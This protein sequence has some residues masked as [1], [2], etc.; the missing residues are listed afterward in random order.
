VYAPTAAYAYQYVGS[1]DWFY[2]GAV[3]RLW[4]Q[5]YRHICKE[6][7]RQ[8]KLWVFRGGK[9]CDVDPIETTRTYYTRAFTSL[10]RL[11]LACA[12]LELDSGAERF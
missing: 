1:G 5:T 4:Q 3:S 2:I 6:N 10:G 9:R 7:T 8:Q 11:Q 12:L